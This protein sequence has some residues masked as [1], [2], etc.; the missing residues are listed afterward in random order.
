MPG[1]SEGTPTAARRG[2][3]GCAVVATGFV[4]AAREVGFTVP[5][6]VRLEG[7]NVEAGRKI[8]KDAEG[9]L[10]TLQTATDLGDAAEKVCG[11]VG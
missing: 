9:E 8:L 7:T 5:L 2:P 10:P 4:N 1:K 3:V 11:A 6:V